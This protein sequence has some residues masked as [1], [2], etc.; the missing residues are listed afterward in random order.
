MDLQKSGRSSKAPATAPRREDL[1]RWPVDRSSVAM[2]DR[3]RDAANQQG[4]AAYRSR[5]IE[6]HFDARSRLEMTEFALACGAGGAIAAIFA[7]ILYI[8]DRRVQVLRRPELVPSQWSTSALDQRVASAQ[9]T[10]LTR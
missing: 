7:G 10:T 6:H 2:S 4:P 5:R 8:N 1:I 9:P 3:E